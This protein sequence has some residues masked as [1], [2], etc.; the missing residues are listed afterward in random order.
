MRLGGRQVRRY[1]KLLG[2]SYRRTAPTVK[3][4][5][6]PARAGRA[7]AVLGGLRKKPRRTG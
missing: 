3:H 1:L 5:Q 2:A 4:K 7:K 6:D